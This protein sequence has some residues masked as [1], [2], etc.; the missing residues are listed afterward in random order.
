MANN[1]TFTD[2]ADTNVQASVNLAT[3]VALVRILLPGRPNASDERTQ[4]EMAHSI[5]KQLLE[6]SSGSIWFS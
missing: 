5:S 3:E 6:A 2:T 1:R 4:A